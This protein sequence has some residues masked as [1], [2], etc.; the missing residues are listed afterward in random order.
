MKK[1]EFYSELESMLEMEPG[2][3]KGDE[4]LANLPGWDSVAILSFIVLADEKLKES[5]SAAALARSQTVADLIAL[6]PNKIS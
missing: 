3:I 1:S 6:F 2:T 5:V 4:A